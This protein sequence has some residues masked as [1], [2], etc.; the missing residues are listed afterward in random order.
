[1][2][3]VTCLVQIA[4]ICEKCLQALTFLNGQQII[5]RDIKSD[6]VLLG[7]NGEVK[8]IDFGFCAQVSDKGKRDTMVGTP[9]WMAPEIVSRKEYNYKVDVWSLGIMTIEM[10]DGEPPYLNE[11]P[12][13]ALFLIASNGKPEVKKKELS[14]ELANFVDQ[15]VEVEVERRPSSV[16][17]LSHAFLKQAENLESLRQNILA[18]REAA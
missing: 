2:L 1:L 4:G 7:M 5:H 16:E 12:L 13:R 11:T 15:C 9:Y 18:A 17:L 3:F 14:R 8:L 6:N 10:I